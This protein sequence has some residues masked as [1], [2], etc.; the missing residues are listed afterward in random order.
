MQFSLEQLVKGLIAHHLGRRCDQV[1]LAHSLRRDL[2][3]DNLSLV[4]IALDLEEQQ[5]SEFPFEFLEYVDTVSDLVALASSLTAAARRTP[6]TSA[7]PRRRPGSPRP[8][9]Y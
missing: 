3:F 9:G 5:C 6:V 1:E 4:G 8:V 2:G 7:A